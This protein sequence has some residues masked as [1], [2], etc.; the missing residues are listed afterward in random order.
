MAT[1]GGGGGLPPR[2]AARRVSFL[3]RRS[4]AAG[5]SGP[6]A[7]SPILLALLL[8]SCLEEPPAVSGAVAGRM[9]RQA[10]PTMLALAAPLSLAAQRW[11][12]CSAALRR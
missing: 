5:V 9:Y 11:R 8:C 6:L 2:T 1:G 3:F 12:E 4:E 7:S 10:E